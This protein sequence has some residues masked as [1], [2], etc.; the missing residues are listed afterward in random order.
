[1][2]LGRYAST[3]AA[4]TLVSAGLISLWLPPGTILGLWVAGS[5]A[6][7]VQV[8]AAAARVRWGSRPERFLAVFA[9]SAAGR[10]GVVGLA[11]GAVFLWEALHPVTTL[12][13]L[14]GYLFALLLLEPVLIRPVAG[15]QT[16]SR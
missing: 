12:V 8:L 7:I 9:W 11:A 10:L 5:V 3:C 6:W 2:G 4:L 16:E 1:M 13:G 15:A 14:A